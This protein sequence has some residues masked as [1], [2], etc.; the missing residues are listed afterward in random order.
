MELPK[1]RGGGKFPKKCQ[2]LTA[3]QTHVPKNSTGVNWG[4]SGGSS[5]CRPGSEDTHQ[6]QR[7]LIYFLFFISVAHTISQKGLS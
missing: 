6:H 7:N 3:P 4:L 5:V 2:I 1:K